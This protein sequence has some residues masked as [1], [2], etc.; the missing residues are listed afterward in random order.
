L[1]GGGY[2]IVRLLLDYVKRHRTR[3]DPVA[4]GQKLFD[5]RHLRQFAGRSGFG[6]D[7]RGTARAAE[8]RRRP[9]MEMSKSRQRTA[10]AAEVR[11]A[12]AGCLLERIVYRV[13]VQVA[14]GLPHFGVGILGGV[15]EADVVVF[16]VGSAGE[17][18]LPSRRTENTS[19]VMKQAIVRIASS[20]AR[21][22]DAEQQDRRYWTSFHLAA[23]NGRCTRLR[24]V[25]YCRH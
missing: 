4:V 20:L 9:L 5:G 24:K 23:E 12:G 1:P 8:V 10:R 7:G 2:D 22:N 13:L 14:G 21:S 3:L 25:F 17:R 18:L 6:K 19:P 16:A 15:D 11:R